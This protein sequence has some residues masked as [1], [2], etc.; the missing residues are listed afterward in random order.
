MEIKIT[1]DISDRLNAAIALIA[2]A[3]QTKT[4]TTAP[5]K[6]A[7]LRVE[8]PE[9]VD[10]L[11][12]SPSPENVTDAKTDATAHE[13]DVVNEDAKPKRVRKKSDAPK[14]EPAPKTAEPAQE[15][16]EPPT[17]PEPVEAPKD[18]PAPAAEAEP[19]PVS[20]P[21]DAPAMTL[22]E[23]RAICVQA[24]KVGKTSVVTGYLN[25]H[26]AA[27]L[28]KLDPALYSKLADTVKAAL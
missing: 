4:V 7:D 28:S 26:G 11:E 5:E 21:A 20:E 10:V 16:T 3:L 23:I 1:L 27:S 13:N 14:A 18:D 17:D 15:T 9:T 22:D 25:A 6:A 8:T 12:A 2:S 24:A 19:E